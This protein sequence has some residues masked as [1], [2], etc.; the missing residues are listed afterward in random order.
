MKH[1]VLALLASAAVSSAY[2]QPDSAY[3]GLALGEFDYEEGDG[4]G[5]DFVQDTVSTWRLMVGYQFMK[6]LAVEGGYGETSTIRDTAQI[7]VFPGVPAQL[8][9][10][11]DIK[12]LTLR[13]LG[14]L[15]FDNGLSLVGGLSYADV[16]QDIDFTIAGTTG[17][18][19][20]SSNDPAYYIGAQYDWD[21]IALRLAYEKYDFDG[22]V[23]AAE[24]TITFFYKL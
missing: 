8:D 23:D 21:R 15:P 4:F 3:Y 5:N 18:I 19:E 14:V 17:S 12:M 20:I 1:Y 16:E 6:H 2:A 22:D 7:I 24:T 9:Y 10:V 11:S 13:L